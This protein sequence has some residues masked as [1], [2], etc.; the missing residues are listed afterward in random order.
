MSGHDSMVPSASRSLEV[1][2]KEPILKPPPELSSLIETGRGSYLRAVE[3]N[4]LVTEA[5]AQ[6]HADIPVQE[7]LRAVGCGEH[8]L[9]LA[10]QLRAAIGS[11]LTKVEGLK[12]C[13]TALG[14][15]AKDGLPAQA[16]AKDVREGTAALLARGEAALLQLRMLHEGAAESCNEGESLVYGSAGENGR[17]LDEMASAFR[18][19]RAEWSRDNQEDGL[20]TWGEVTACVNALGAVGPLKDMRVGGDDAVSKSI[21]KVMGEI[22]EE[23]ARLSK[24]ECGKGVEGGKGGKP[25]GGGGNKKKSQAVMASLKLAVEAVVKEGRQFGVPLMEHL[26]SSGAVAADEEKANIGGMEEEEEEEEAPPK[27]VK[28]TQNLCELLAG[29]AIEVRP[30]FSRINST[31]APRPLKQSNTRPFHACVC[32]RAF[33]TSSADSISSVLLDCARTVFMASFASIY[34]AS[35]ARII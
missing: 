16:G 12:A 20:V 2:V 1:Q 5:K 9:Y 32:A 24:I 6:P 26:A 14:S 23:R 10:Q 11:A 18:S 31:S 28:M 4:L 25:S 13:C 15:F 7:A 21:R 8:C 33:S 30:A 19:A 27:L 35:C 22:E 34:H 3:L 17:C 29:N